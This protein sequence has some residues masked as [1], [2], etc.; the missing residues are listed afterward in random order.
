[1][2][3]S[4]TKQKSKKDKNYK[5]KDSQHRNCEWQCENLVM[6]EIYLY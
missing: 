6:I 2:P 5:K 1:M 3:D 4:E